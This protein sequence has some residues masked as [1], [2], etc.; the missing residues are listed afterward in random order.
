MGNSLNNEERLY[1]T[2][3][4][5]FVDNAIDYDYIAYMVKNYD[6]KYIEDVLFNYVAPACYFNGISP[7]PPVCYFF[8]EEQLL[9]EIEKIKSIKNKFLGRLKMS[10][11]TYYLKMVFKNEWIQLKSRL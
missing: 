9:T 5:I 7:V 1:V 2:L 11:F 6:I 4:L 8:D 10:F 3:S